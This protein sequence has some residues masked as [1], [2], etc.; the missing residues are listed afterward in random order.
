MAGKSPLRFDEIGY[1]SEIKLEILRKYA[2]AFTTIISAQGRKG[3][4]LHPVYIDGFAGAGEHISKTTG[5]TVPGSPKI[6]LEIV[7]PFSAYH[8]VDLDQRRADNLREMSA[9]N[10]NAHVHTGDCNQILA[11]D[12]LPLVRYDQYRRGLCLLDPYGLDLHWEVVRAAADTRA[13][14]IFLNFP[15]ADMNRNV[16]W[17]NPEGVDPNDVAR[18]TAFWGDDS[19]RKIVYTPIPTLF[20][21]PVD[22]KTA[23]NRMIADAYR[24]RLKEVAGFKYVP[25]P[26]PMRNSKNAVVYYLFFASPNAVGAKI[27]KE[28][29]DRY[30]NYGVR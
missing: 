13:V 20:G 5:D 16:F 30:R 24:R 17:Q 6:A 15:V 26:I 14:E 2:V 21:G 8:F 11:R 22:L 18:M 28:I 9:G 4:T 10:T 27:V 25:D 3:P 12:V 1:W 29:F 23:D 7:P 19:W